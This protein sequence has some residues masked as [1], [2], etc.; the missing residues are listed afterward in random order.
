MVQLRFFPGHLK[1]IINKLLANTDIN[2]LPIYIHR[3][4]IA[5]VIHSFHKLT[6]K[7]IS[8]FFHIVDILYIFS[9]FSG[10]G[11]QISGGA[12]LH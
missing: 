8:D 2:L 4:F 9:D 1:T 5:E 12:G 7:T 11:V 3:L 10:S 6:Q